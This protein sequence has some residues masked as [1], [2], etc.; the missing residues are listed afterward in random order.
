[1]YVEGRFNIIKMA[2][3]PNLS[4]RVR[5]IQMQIPGSNL[6]DTDKLILE[7]HVKA[8]DTERPRSTEVEE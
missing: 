8:K 3:L 1:M 7:S 6:V 4:R 5:E 2:I